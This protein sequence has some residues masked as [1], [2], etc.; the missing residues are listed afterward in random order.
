MSLV[1]PNQVMTE[2]KNQ[3]LGGREPETDKDYQLI[4]NFIAV[5]LDPEIALAACNLMQVLYD[6]P[7][8]LQTIKEIVEFQL[9]NRLITQEVKYPEIGS[10]AF[11]KGP[12]MQDWL[13]TDPEDYPECGFEAR[14][15]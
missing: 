15:E 1:S 4:I 3:M 10:V 6:M 2:A 8:S 9:N 11:E 14:G 5:N 7:I 13:R 12:T